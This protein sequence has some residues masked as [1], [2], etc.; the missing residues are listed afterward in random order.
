[1]LS[2]QETG[3]SEI[4]TTAA[5]PSCDPRGLSSASPVLTASDGHVAA[6]RSTTPTPFRTR[7]QR[8]S[9][10]DQKGDSPPSSISTSPPIRSWELQPCRRWKAHVIGSC[11]PRPR[12]SGL[13]VMSTRPYEA[14]RQDHL[15]RQTTSKIA[16][17][18]DARMMIRKGSDPS[19]IKQ[20]RP[21]RTEGW[22]TRSPDSASTNTRKRPYFPLQA[23]HFSWHFL[24]S[25]QKAC[26]AACALGGSLPVPFSTGKD[27]VPASGP[28]A[29]AVVGYCARSAELFR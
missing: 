12:P 8:A 29:F 14:F 6:G 25:V 5:S 27:G 17:S 20:G 10:H 13:P 7:L 19:L 22:A 1:M 21:Q 18:L 11:Y 3:R 28:K 23:L 16:A 9:S 2:N 15:P 26:L 24:N 4:G